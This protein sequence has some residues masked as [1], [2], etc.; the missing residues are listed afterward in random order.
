MFKKSLLSLA[1]L[2]ATAVANADVLT[3]VKPLGFIANAITDQK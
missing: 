3:T 2:G 1:L